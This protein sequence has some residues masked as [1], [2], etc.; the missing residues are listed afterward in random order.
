[1]NDEVKKWLAENGRKG[2]L[3]R[4]KLYSKAQIK[5]WGAKGGRPKKISTV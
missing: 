4:K 5:A 1:M 2:G 3:K